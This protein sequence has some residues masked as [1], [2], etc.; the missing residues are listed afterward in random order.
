MRGW[1]FNSSQPFLSNFSTI[2]RISLLLYPPTAV[3]FVAVFLMEKTEESPGNAERHI[4]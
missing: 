2:R 3:W 4:S 1:E